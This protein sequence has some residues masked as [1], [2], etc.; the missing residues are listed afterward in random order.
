M[1]A[2]GTD[3][4]PDVGR[5][6]E[7]LR[8]LVA[9][10]QACELRALDV[11]TGYGKRP[12]AGF[13]DCDHLS[14]MAKE[15]IKLTKI[16]SG[17]YFTINPLSLDVLS[18]RCNRVGPAERGESAG[19]EAVV[20]RR[21]MLIDCDPVRLTGIC[22]T[23]GE[24]AD[25]RHVAAE[26]Q[27]DLHDHGWP[28]PILADSGNGWHLF[29]RVDLPVDDGELVKRCLL[30]LAA[31]HST[32]T[33]K[34]DCSVFDPP[35]IAR[36]PGCL[37]RKGDHTPGRPHRL[38]GLVDVPTEIVAVPQQLLQDLAAECKDPEATKQR[39]VP[40]A[41]NGAY[42]HRLLVDKW[43]QS[44]GV[45][46]RVKGGPDSKGRTVYVLKECPFNSAHCDPDSCIMQ[47]ADGQMSVQCFH[48]SCTG[49]GWQE[50]KERIGKPAA[51]DYDP[52]LK[53]KRKHSAPAPTDDAQSKMS[54][55]LIQSYFQEHYE[56][57]FRRGEVL[58]SAKLRREVKANEATFAPTEELLSKL[59][60][61][62]DAPTNKEGGLAW[63]ALP[64]H[65]RTWA[66][67]A[68]REVL[69]TLPEEADAPEIDANA[70]TDFGGLV[71]TALHANV[72][73]GEVREKG[74][75]D[76]HTQAERRSLI[77]WCVKWAKP[78]DWS[79]IRS[80]CIWTRLDPDGNVC[81]AIRADLFGQVG[82]RGLATISHRTFASLCQ[83]YG[84]GTNRDGEAKAGGSRVVELYQEFLVGRM[85][86]TASARPSNGRM[87][88]EKPRTHAHAHE[89]NDVLPSIGEETHGK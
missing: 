2:A 88:A 25:A 46:F 55:K 80:Y 86:V 63:N 16:S 66:R 79:S 67:V 28:D 22:A 54:H 33:A 9:P 4:L 6:L 81:V 64:Q 59:A 23:D 1:S 68:W 17:V 75:K 53:G 76:E 85:G 83:Q 69:D 39:T 47:A 14:T 27:N 7:A 26:V 8:L 49:L 15:A 13:F 77:H 38:T 70:K 29:Y 44:R 50:F 74:T 45:A 42:E 18:K 78:G 40:T 56:P 34:V 41:G 82:P 36:L 73:L 11:A 89:E 71:A 35:R 37:N 51:D 21:W 48:D 72:C 31:K 65:F 32:S 10:G 12:H 3:T 62:S 43:L 19:A 60:N 5:I 87:D 30:A 24:K 58:Y 52:P 84:V 57:V 61:A 20:R